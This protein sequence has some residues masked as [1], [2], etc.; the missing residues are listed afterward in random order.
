MR[1]KYRVKAAGTQESEQP[2]ST[3]LSLT[4]QVPI[5]AVGLSVANSQLCCRQGRKNTGVPG[6]H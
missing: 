4:A 1:G 6:F 3:L 2:K 5:H